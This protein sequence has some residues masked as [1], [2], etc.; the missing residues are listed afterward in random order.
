LTYDDH[1]IAAE[2]AAILV[3]R[4]DFTSGDGYYN[5]SILIQKMEWKA[6]LNTP[7]IVSLD[8]I[9]DALAYPSIR[10]VLE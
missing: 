6:M 8:G 4:C 1:D 7:V 10:S 9:Q 5:A 2:A 3:T